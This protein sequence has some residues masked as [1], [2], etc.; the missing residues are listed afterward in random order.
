M[1][2]IYGLAEAAKSES[3]NHEF[4]RV[5][6]FNAIEKFACRSDVGLVI[7][8]LNIATYVKYGVSIFGLFSLVIGIA[9]VHNSMFYL[10]REVAKCS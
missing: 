7:G 5:R 9:C 1:L 4:G 6:M 3:L 8:V 10:K 2:S